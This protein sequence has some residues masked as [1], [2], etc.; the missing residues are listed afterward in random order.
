MLTNTFTPTIS[1]TLS[2]ILSRRR[3]VLLVCL[4]LLVIAPPLY[5]DPFTSCR[6]VTQ[7]PEAQCNTLVALYNNTAGFFSYQMLVN[8]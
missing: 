6:D 3:P 4:A 7:M 1:P 5:A 8:L 2:A